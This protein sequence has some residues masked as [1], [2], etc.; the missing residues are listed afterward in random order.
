MINKKGMSPARRRRLEENMMKTIQNKLDVKNAELDQAFTQGNDEST[1]ALF[2]AFC[3]YL[4]EKHGLDTHEITTELA[5]I[6]TYVTQYLNKDKYPT[7][8][9]FLDMVEEKTGV[10]IVV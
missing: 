7:T 6:D 4:H 5:E 10:R 1:K 9:E 2:G 8:Q 3:L